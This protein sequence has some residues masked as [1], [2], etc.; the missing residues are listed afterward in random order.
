MIKLILIYVS[1]LFMW[2]YINNKLLF[3]S[4]TF[5]HSSHILLLINGENIF[6]IGYH[7]AQMRPTNSLS[8]LNLTNHSP[9]L[10]VIQYINVI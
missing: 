5:T 6:E 2:Q 1:L 9:M 10:T 8:D 7:T 4:F 3:Y